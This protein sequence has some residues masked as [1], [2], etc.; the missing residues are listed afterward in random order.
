MGR[1]AARMTTLEAP[2][3]VEL[4]T[5]EGRRCRPRRRSFSAVRRLAASAIE[6]ASTCRKYL[7]DKAIEPFVGDHHRGDVAPSAPRPQATEG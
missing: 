4:F 1:R 5:S 3:A 2:M 7:P 6:R